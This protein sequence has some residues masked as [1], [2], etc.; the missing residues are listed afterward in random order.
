MN[1]PIDQQTFNQRM[2]AIFNRRQRALEQ[3]AVAARACLP[4]LR[5][6]KLEHTAG[7]LAEPL[8][9]LDAVR[10]EM[11]E[12]A[13]SEPGALVEYMGRRMAL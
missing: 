5:D 2:D 4:V 12:L 6:Q 8:F 13:R 7:Q 3:I 9:L 10:Q 1:K 11:E